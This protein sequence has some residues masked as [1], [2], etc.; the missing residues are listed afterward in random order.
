MLRINHISKN[1][2]GIKAVQDVSFQIAE[3]EIVGLVGHNGSGK[4]TTMKIITGCCAPQEGGVSLDGIDVWE[5]PLRAKEQ[6]GY[7]PEIPPLYPDM[8][9]EEELR[10][11]CGLRKCFGKRASEEID[12]ACEKLNLGE[13]RKR[14][15]RNLS[16]GYRQRVGFAQA[17]IGFPKLIVLDEPMAG[18]D[19]EQIFELREMILELRRQ[20]ML[21][22]SSHILSELAMVCDRIVI[23]NGGR[24]AAND[25]LQGLRDKMWEHDELILE[26]DGPDAEVS[27]LLPAFPGVRT[28]KKK[29]KDGRPQYHIRTERGTDIRGALC[30]ELYRRGYYIRELHLAEGTLEDVFM[31]LTHGESGGEEGKQVK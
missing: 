24:L 11:V 12:W 20:H 13:T 26:T 21:L 29:S 25:S 22:L 4:S 5:E 19:P 15:I 6:I 27:S 28:V 9:V 31:A 1:F 23:L 14:L 3:G 30:A 7:L 17:L 2:G 8:T 16:K 18:L 10:F